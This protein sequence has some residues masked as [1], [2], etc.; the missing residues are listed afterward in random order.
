MSQHQ[1]KPVEVEDLAV[2]AE[3]AEDVKGGAQ[4]DYFLRL[5]G[6]DGE[7]TD[8]REAGAPSISEVVVTKATDLS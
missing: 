8:S 2:N 3:N 7:A 5:K 1:E 4:V 6:I